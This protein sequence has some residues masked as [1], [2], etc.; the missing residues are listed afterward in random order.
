MVGLYSWGEPILHPDLNGIAQAIAR[1][2]LFAGLST[3]ASKKTSFTDSTAHFR[4]MIFSMPGWSQASYDKVHGLKFDRIVSNMEASIANMRHRGYDGR[5]SLSFHTYQFNIV[6]ELPLARDWCIKNGVVFEA[7]AAY[8]NDYEPNIEYRKGTLSREKL[9][10]ISKQLFLHY[11]DD[12]V[13]SQPKD[14]VC[15]QW[16]KILTLNHRSEV[17]L[18]CVLPEGNDSYSLGSIFDLSKQQ[19]LFSKTTD[20]ECTTCLE[21][22][23]AYW[24]H[25]PMMF[26]VT[27]PPAPMQSWLRTGTTRLRAAMRQ[28]LKAG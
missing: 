6:E 28:L 8:I 4:Q 18:C 17:L 22:G 3:N 23:V 19:I 24:A 11:V 20:K 5:I 16:D 7:Y 26:E 9:D 2:G 25:N 12:L 10:E 15:P 14:W 1:R 21:T 27:N 13:A